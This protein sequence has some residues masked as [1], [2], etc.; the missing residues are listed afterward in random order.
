MTRKIA[1]SAE[2]LGQPGEAMRRLPTD[3]WRA[4]VTFFLLE[5]IQNRHKNNYGAQ[6]SAARKAGFGKP[7]SSA[8][9]MAHL[10]W[11]LMSDDRVIAAVAEES[12]KLLRTGA[13]EAVKA[14]LAGVR[15]PASKDHARFVAMVLD[16]AD[17]VE[18]A[19]TVKVEHETKIAIGDLN[20]R[21]ME[22]SLKFGLDPQKVLATP[23]A[24]LIE[25]ECQEVDQEEKTA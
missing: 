14:V 6:A 11:K 24:P 8:R 22:V 16:R 17:P 23:A 25:G 5:T 13:P 4:F 18:T 21:L 19:H 7:K 3:R 10:G 9:V 2:D 20:E 12:R 15:N 1:I